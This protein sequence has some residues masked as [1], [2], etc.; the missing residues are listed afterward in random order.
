MPEFDTPILRHRG[1]SPFDS[2]NGCSG[3]CGTSAW[4]AGRLLN[5]CLI[6]V[7][8]FC[9][10]LAPHD[11]FKQ[12]ITK[13]LW[14]PAFLAGGKAEYPLGSDHLGRDLLTRLMYGTR[15][16]LVVGISAVSFMCWWGSV[17]GLSPVTSAEKRIPSSPSW[18]I[19]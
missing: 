12:D 3:R 16:S 1:S 19:A 11:P 14:K 10:Y 2:G 7:A 9:P 18:S 4:G 8:V 15:I 6:F 5:F 17:S 13:R